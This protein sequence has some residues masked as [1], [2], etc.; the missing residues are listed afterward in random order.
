MP[1]LGKFARIAI[2]LVL[3]IDR[4]RSARGTSLGLS[5]VS[6]KPGRSP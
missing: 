4:V 1:R 3:L 2:E 6:D 5:C